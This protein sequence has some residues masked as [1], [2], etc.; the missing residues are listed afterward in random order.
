MKILFVIAEG[1]EELELVAPLDI[2]RRAGAECV[3]AS[4]EETCEVK[5][6]NGIILCA[7]ATFSTVAKEEWDAVVLAGGPS[8][9]SLR[10]DA[11]LRSF[12]QVSVQKERY[13]AAICAAPLILLD[14]GLLTNKRV[15]G[16]SSIRREISDLQDIEVVVDGKIITS[17]GA[18]TAVAFGL[19][20]VEQFFGAEKRREI[21]QSI[22]CSL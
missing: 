19:S 13:I 7:D 1:V 16:H 17:K 14:A 18:G 10:H 15:T 2:L 5:G 22:E 4:M 11:A 21:A 8:S 9:F 6:R 12:L 3:L 20:L